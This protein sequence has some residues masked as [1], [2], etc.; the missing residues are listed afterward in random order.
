[1]EHDYLYEVVGVFNFGS[2]FIKW[3]R[4]FIA[5]E[6]VISS[7][8]VFFQVVYLWNV[9]FSGLSDFA[10]SFSLCNRGARNFYQEEH[11]Y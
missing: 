11:G 10:A 3:I 9:G 6:V 7:T 8:M 5:K 1:M 2:D 4:H